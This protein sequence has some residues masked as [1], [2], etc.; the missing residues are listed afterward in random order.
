M[1]NHKKLVH[2]VTGKEYSMSDA[3]RLIGLPVP[4]IYHRVSRGDKGL[5]LWRPCDKRYLKY[6]PELGERETQYSED[7]LNLGTRTKAERLR[8]LNAIPAPTKFDLLYGGN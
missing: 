2:P 5:H 6:N 7:I 4:S 3:A 1:I 8:N